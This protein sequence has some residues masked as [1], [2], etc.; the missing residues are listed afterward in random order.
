MFIQLTS[1]SVPHDLK[2]STVPRTK[3]DPKSISYHSLGEKFP[4]IESYSTVAKRK[5]NQYSVCGKA[6]C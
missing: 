5:V 6:E 4:K 2:F 3:S 1:V